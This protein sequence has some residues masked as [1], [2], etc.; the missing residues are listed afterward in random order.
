[1]NTLLS[2]RVMFRQFNV[3]GEELAQGGQ[4]MYNVTAMPSDKDTAPADILSAHRTVRPD[5]RRCNVAGE[6]YLDTWTFTLID[7]LHGPGCYYGTVPF[8]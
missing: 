2:E 5:S 6:L 7:V 1:M 4:W 8:G 3:N